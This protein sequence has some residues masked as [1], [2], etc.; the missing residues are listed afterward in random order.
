MRTISVE[1]TSLDA[2]VEEAQDERIVITR[3]GKP[4][5]LVV[6]VEG[7]D[8]EQLELGSS[9]KLWELITHRRQQ[10]TVTREQLEQ[11]IREQGK[12]KPGT[13]Q[14]SAAPGRDSVRKNRQHRGEG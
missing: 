2:C 12:G 8:S 14:P 4:V 9:A 6:G 10:G 1:K 5:A 3:D 13:A 7:L 11:K